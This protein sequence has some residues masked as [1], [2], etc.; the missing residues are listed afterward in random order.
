[1]EHEGK[2]VLVTG[3]QQG[4]GRSMALAFAK[5]GADVAINWHDDHEKA[6]SVADEVKVFGN[7]VILVKGDVSVVADTRRIIMETVSSLGKIDIL[8]NNA[9]MFPRVAFLEMEEQ[10][11]DFV[12]DINLKGTFF[13][14]QAAARAMVQTGNAGCII[15]LSS[16]AV[17]GNSPL[18][19]HYCSSKSG[20]I[21]LTRASALELALHNIRVN[22]IAPG[23]T[24]TAQP[25]YGSSEVELVERAGQSPSGRMVKPEE[26][27]NM[28]V[29]LCSEKA[30]M[31]TGQVYH[32]NGGTYFP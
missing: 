31:V 32:V 25:R 10:D 18:G 4:I 1:M 29:F 28:A 11:W 24:D 12:L 30:A 16:Q 15:N 23:L 20:I 22:A 13:C 7:K 5:S 14:S 8:I 2:A 27:A 6:Q 21:G 9:G 3:A 19:V 17:S 26:I